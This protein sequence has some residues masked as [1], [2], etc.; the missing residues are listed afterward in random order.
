MVQKRRITFSLD[1]HS[2][3]SP[4]QLEARGIFLNGHV[5]VQ[6]RICF[7]TV[8]RQLSEQ[9]NSLGMPQLDTLYQRLMRSLFDHHRALTGGDLAAQESA[10]GALQALIHEELQKVRR[11]LPALGQ[12]QSAGDVPW[13]PPQGSGDVSA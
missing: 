3:V 7:P 10:L 2:Q 5:Q 4:E 13:Q 8:Q 12:P 11:A 1:E 9:S 6:G